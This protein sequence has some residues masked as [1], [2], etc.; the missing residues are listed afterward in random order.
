VFARQ[1]QGFRMAAERNVTLSIVTRVVVCAAVLAISVG[2][3][4]VLFET[5]AVPQETDRGN[6]VPRVVVMRADPVALQRPWTGYGSAEA[7]DSADVPARITAVVVEVSDDVVAGRAVR[8]GQLLARL[9]DSDF[10]RQVEISTETIKQLD[11][12]LA[13]IEVEER[14]WQ[15]R[16]T[17]AQEDRRLAQSDLERVQRALDAGAAKERE[18][19]QANQTLLAAERVLIAAQEE[20]NKVPTR[21]A[22]LA[23]QRGRESA[24]LKQ[25]QEN[26]QRCRIVS[27]LDGVL[28]AVDVEL[29]ENVA[30]GQRIARVVN[31]D[32]VEVILRLPAGARRDV[33]IGDAVLL[34]ATGP[35]PQSW[36]ASVSRISPVDD[37]AT[38]TM[39]A[40]VELRQDATDDKLLPPGKFVQGTVTCGKSQ[41]RTVVPHRAVLNERLL[42]VEDG[43]LQSR[44]AVVDFQ[45]QGE[46]PQSGLPDRD[47]SVL[48]DPL[49][50]GALVVVDAAGGLAPGMTVTVVPSSELAAA[51]G[52]TIAPVPTVAPPTSPR[53][54]TTP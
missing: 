40:F 1:A 33:H 32:H 43:V 35:Q 22:A 31:L 20:M 11:A 26:V 47:W 29:G 46:L 13:Q 24:A 27:P 52:R 23:G 19:D 53:Q 45:L 28:A 9:D 5:R 42:V 36:N 15:Q 49:P 3:Y 50:A 51:P 17:L 25:A 8:A 6:G 48:R 30:A 34:E 16:M 12:Q 2:I 4:W 44:D 14:S 7:M 21:K 18:V 38:R 54:G 41:A 10:L 39:T 37:E